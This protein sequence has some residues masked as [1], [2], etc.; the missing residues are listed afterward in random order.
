MPYM[1]YIL[2][3]NMLAH[4]YLYIASKANKNKTPEWGTQQHQH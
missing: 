1:C 2:N 3:N 4:N